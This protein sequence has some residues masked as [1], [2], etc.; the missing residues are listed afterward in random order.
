MRRHRDGRLVSTPIHGVPF[1]PPQS[2]RCGNRLPCPAVVN[3]TATSESEPLLIA[4]AP[5]AVLRR[6]C[7]RASLAL[8]AAILT[9]GFAHGEPRHAIAMHGE[10][11]LPAGFSHFRYANPDAPKGGRLVQGVL[12]TFDSLNPFIVK[13]LPPQ[14]MRAPLVSGSNII[15]ELRGRK[16]D[17]ARL[18]RAVHALRPD[19]AIGRDRR[20]AHLRDLHARS[21]GALL[22]RQ[23]GDGG[24]RRRSPGSCCATRA[25]RT[26]A[27]I[28][29][30][31]R[32][33]RRWPSASCGSISAAAKTASCR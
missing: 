26:T 1:Q 11:A 17:G 10:P 7:A 16:P 21:G 29:P 8:A 5:S 22:R 18:R 4:P 2:Y 12:G 19:R 6:P 23:A 20:G 28:T 31:S 3:S 27:S 32:R 33:P 15:A 13:G 24:G 14:G 30:R 25:G 9:G